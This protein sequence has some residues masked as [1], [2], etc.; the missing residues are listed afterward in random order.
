MDG[1]L[2]DLVEVELAVELDL[3]DVDGELLE[4]LDEGDLDVL[5]D[6]V[7]GV[8]ALEDEVL[9]DLDGA[10]GLGGMRYLKESFLSRICSARRCPTWKFWRRECRAMRTFMRIM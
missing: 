6:P 4:V 3:V 8:G 5:E 9:V 10:G 7:V 1:V 2:G